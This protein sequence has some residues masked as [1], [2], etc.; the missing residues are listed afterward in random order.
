METKI[1]IMKNS[2]FYN[3]PRYTAT[4]RFVMVEKINNSSLLKGNSLYELLKTCG[5]D[6]YTTEVPLNDF[7]KVKKILNLPFK[8]KTVKI[9]EWLIGIIGEN[10]YDV[11]FNIWDVELK[12]NGMTIFS[13]RRFDNIDFFNLID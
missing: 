13:A 9:S 8:T 1:N 2:L 3:P 6:E 10:R 12:K 11:Y 5:F 4:H 7:N